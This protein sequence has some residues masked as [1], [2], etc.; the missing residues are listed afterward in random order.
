MA[1]PLL[2]YAREVLTAH[3]SGDDWKRFPLPDGAD[4]A[5]R[6]GCFVSLKVGGRL[7]G[8][9]GTVLPVRPTLGEEVAENALAAATRD[10]RFAPLQANELSALR[11]SL[12][13]LSPPEPVASLLALDPRRYGVLVRA[14][15]RVGVLLPDLTGV[16]TA[17]AQVEICC[18]KAGIP[19]RASYTLERFTVERY[20]E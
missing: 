5:A 15:K 6:R 12:D 14:G 8:C 10:S 3:L 9:I 18:R 7:R 20:E 19:Y 13:L 2:T 1:H 16:D 4:G 17:A 11:L